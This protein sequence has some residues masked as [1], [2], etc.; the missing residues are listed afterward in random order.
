MYW[1]VYCTDADGVGEA[2]KAVFDEHVNYVRS[3]PMRILAGGPLLS[4]DIEQHSGSLLV[5]EAATRSDVERFVEHAPFTTH[6]IWAQTT[7]NRFV[8]SGKDPF[9]L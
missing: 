2:R 7:I 9:A 1:I 4:D 8:P 3:E 5:V 6:R